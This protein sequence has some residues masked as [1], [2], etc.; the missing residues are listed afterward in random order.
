M[1]PACIRKRDTQA[2]QIVI[3]V[4]QWKNNN[5]ASPMNI[6]LFLIKPRMCHM[7]ISVQGM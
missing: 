7:V 5:P 3:L 1:V 2:S 6:D 4:E